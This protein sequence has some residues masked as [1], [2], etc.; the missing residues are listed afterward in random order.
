MYAVLGCGRLA[1]EIVEGLALDKKE[2]LLID[3]NEETLD[4]FKKEGYKVQKVKALTLKVI[5]KHAKDWSKVFVLGDE[6]AANIR[7]A[8]SVRKHL[9]SAQIIINAPDKKSE[10]ALGKID[11]V[12][13]FRASESAKSA[14][15]AT[16]AALERQ[17]T[18]LHLRTLLQNTKGTIGIFI[19]NNPDPDSMASA[20]AFSRICEHLDVSSKIYYGGEISHQENKEMVRLLDIQLSQITGEDELA[21]ALKNAAKVVMVETVIPGDNNALPA[22]FVPNMV[23][24]HHSTSRDV[25]ASDLVDIRSDVGALS[26]V[27][28]MYLQELD[29]EMDVNLATA[30]LYGLRVDTKAFTR[31]VSPTD[32]K[33]AAF[34][35]PFADGDMLSRIES[36]PMTSDTLDVIGRAIVN[37]EMREGVLFSAVGYVEERDALPQAAEFLMREKDV[38]VVGL[39]G[40]RG[41]N[42]HISARSIDPGIHIGEIVK[43]SFGELGSGGGH[44]TSGGVQ[45]PL[46]RVNV[47]DK[48]DKELVANI[49]SNMIRKLFFTGLGVDIA[50]KTV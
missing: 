29:V 8:K 46:E 44:A 23:L 49:V 7:L 20:M 38:K 6:G 39:C 1:F 14:L 24:D 35:S 11:E 42:I 32:L 26:T 50:T 25:S 9:P 10:A 22:D 2:I 15:V 13:T 33:A 43:S 28:T 37:R 17:Q 18:A 12:V 30:L 41:Y 34:L 27:L 3:D 31:N 5:E 36:P 45:I 40:I 47:P 48:S 4:L 21:I 16:L 19:H